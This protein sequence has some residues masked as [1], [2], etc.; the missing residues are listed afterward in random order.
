ML[1]IM[2]FP[3]MARPLTALDQ[4]PPHL[5]MVHD[6][7][8]R[9]GE[10]IQWS[11]GRKVLVDASQSS[12]AS[13]TALGGGVITSSSA[14]Q[15]VSDGNG[16]VKVAGKAESVVDGVISSQTQASTQ[17]YVSLHIKEDGSVEY[18]V[19]SA[20]A[21]SSQ[22]SSTTMLL[23]P[24][25]SSALVSG[26]AS[27]SESGPDAKATHEASATGTLTASEGINT[28]LISQNKPQS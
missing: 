18:I 14:A 15:V 24:P 8:R 16:N 4:I 28:V 7:T 20:S 3:G 17:G 12:K 23:S 5:D 19:N 26:E 25:H 21:A 13:A 27:T 1:A 22:D 9:E 10:N 2:A 6:G 11:T